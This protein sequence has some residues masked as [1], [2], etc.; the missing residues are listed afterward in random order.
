VIIPRLGITL[1][2]AVGLTP[3]QEVSKFHACGALGESYSNT[4]LEGE[5]KMFHFLRPSIP[6]KGAGDDL[7]DLRSYKH[8]NAFLITRFIKNATDIEVSSRFQILLQGTEMHCVER[9]SLS[10]RPVPSTLMQHCS[11]A[12]QE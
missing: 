1:D 6:S 7:E 10:A 5:R 4:E 2:H 3:L 12:D 8:F 9:N 11:I